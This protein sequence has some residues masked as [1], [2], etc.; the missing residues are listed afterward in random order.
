M[1][2]KE[3]DFLTSQ[4]ALRL[5]GSLCIFE[6][7]LTFAD[8]LTYSSNLN[9]YASLHHSVSHTYVHSV[10][11]VDCPNIILLKNIF[12]ILIFRL[13][14]L[15]SSV[16]FS[17]PNLSPLIHTDPFPQL[18]IHERSCAPHPTYCTRL[19][20]HLSPRNLCMSVRGS[21]EDVCLEDG[22]T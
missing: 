16:H 8:L 19:P 5:K 7:S 18:V 11:A 20:P 21:V 12:L 6:Q 14:L 15:P 10:S 1:C 2:E 9:C 3:S 13:P 22:A 4:L 17:L